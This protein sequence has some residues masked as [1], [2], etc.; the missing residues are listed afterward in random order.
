[1]RRLE[2]LCKIL[3]D[4]VPPS[5]HEM[6]LHIAV[7]SSTHRLQVASCRALHVIS[8]I[9]IRRT[10]RIVVASFVLVAR[11]LSV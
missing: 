9:V 8:I 10:M 6:I 11:C 2:V 5:H 7:P 4:S 3:Q 1:M